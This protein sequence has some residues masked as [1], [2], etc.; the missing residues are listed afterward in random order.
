VD[1][2]ATSHILTDK[3]AFIKFD[4]NFEASKQF[5]EL[6]DGR[7]QAGATK[8]RGDACVELTDSDGTRRTCILKDVLLVPD[9]PV[10]IFSVQ[11]AVKNVLLSH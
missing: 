11:A 1:C 8:A 7:R 2:G 9:F 6:A 4:D 3:E 10:N 5:N